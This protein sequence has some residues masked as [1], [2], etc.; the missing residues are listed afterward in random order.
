[1]IIVSSSLAAT[2][3][4]GRVDGC[5]SAAEYTINTQIPADLMSNTGEPS[6]VTV[7]NG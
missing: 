5:L 2:R 1:M 4:L 3:Q 7:T 6:W